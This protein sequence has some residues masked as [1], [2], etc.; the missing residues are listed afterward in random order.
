MMEGQVENIG[1]GPMT[2]F[3]A[4]SILLCAE[5]M[6]R[7]VEN[8]APGCEGYHVEIRAEYADKRR[9]RCVLGRDD[10]LLLPKDAVSF[11]VGA[12]AYRLEVFDGELRLPE[13]PL[14]LTLHAYSHFTRLGTQAADAQRTRKAMELMR[15]Y[16]ICVTG[17]A[18]ID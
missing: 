9:I 5:F 3:G 1:L 18:Y 10:S 6:R 16:F 11:A 12:Y 2:S 8:V 4:P 17:T 14:A 15:A 7:T 13:N